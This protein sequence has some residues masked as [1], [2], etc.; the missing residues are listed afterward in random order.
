MSP[1]SRLAALGVVL[2]GVATPGVVI[3]AGGGEAFWLCLPVVLLTAASSRTRFGAALCAAA[4]VSLT[5]AA[6]VV[7]QV[8]PPRSLPLALFIPA[9]SVTVLVAVRERLERERDA[10]RRFALCDPLTGIANR[11]CLR[12][13]IEYEVARHTRGHTSFALLMLDLDG[14]KVLN[15]RFGHAAGDDLLRDVA[16]AMERA[17]RSQDTV[18]RIGGDEFC[19]LAPETDLPGARRLTARI[20][21]AVGDVTTG[22]DAL[23]ASS[24]VAL[25]PDDGLSPNALLQAADQRLLSAKRERQRGR[26]RSRAA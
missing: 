25:F 18:A 15:D 24:G 7:S 9:A 12:E 23:G 11:R 14:F 6:A 17:L 5:A 21:S 20:E 1:S 19:V 3:L 8:R 16:A 22:V 26:I 13:R 10:L 4:F 2:A